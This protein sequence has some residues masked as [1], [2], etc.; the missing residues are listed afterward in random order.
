MF[1]KY[2]RLILMTARTMQMMRL[3]QIAVLSLATWCMSANAN[4][5]PT[6]SSGG[7]AGSQT[8]TKTYPSALSYTIT[9]SGSSAAPFRFDGQGGLNESGSA[10]TA[11]YSPGIAVDVANSATRL[12][13][14]G[15][16]APS[17]GVC[18]NRGTVTIAFSQPVTNPVLHVAGFG[19]ASSGVNHSPIFRLTSPAT[20]VT[21]SSQGTSTNMNVTATSFTSGTLNGSSNCNSS[22]TGAGC[23]SVRV[24]GT[25]TTLT[26]A[27]DLRASGSLSAS[28]FDTIG[29]TISVDEDFSDAPTTS[30]NSAQAPSHIVGDLRLGAT[31][32]ADNVNVTAA[33]VS[34]FPVGAGADNNGSNGD[35]VD[36]DAIS[37]FPPLV[38]GATSYSLT[39]PISGAS[40]AGLVCGWIDFDRNN[41]FVVTERACAAF[42]AGQTSVVLGWNAANGNAPTGLTAGNNY[43]RL[44]AGYTASQIQTADGKGRADSGEVED[45]RISIADL[46]ISGTVFQDTLGELLADGTI[47]SAA[48]PALSGRTVRLFNSAGTQVTTTTTAANGSYTFTGVA[49]GTYYVAVDAP[50]VNAAGNSTNILLEQTYA[51][52]GTGNDGAA[53]G[54]TGYGPLC[55]GPQPGY[56]QQGATTTGNSASAAG[57]VACYGGRRGVVGDSGTTN[58]NDKEH[59][60]RVVMGNTNIAGVDFGFSPYVATNV[61][62]SGQGSLLQFSRNYA[63][64]NAN[65]TYSLRVVPAVPTNASGGGGNWWEVEMATA[66]ASQ[67]VLSRVTNRIV[68]FDGTPYSNTNGTT[69]LNPNPGDMAPA[70]TAVG[71]Q[72]ATLGSIPRPDFALRYTGPAQANTVIIPIDAGGNGSSVR[73]FGLR[74][75]NA[76][77]SLISSIAG[78]LTVA[79]NAFGHRPSGLADGTGTSSAILLNATTYNG[80]IAIS[81]NY[82]ASVNYGVVIRVQSPGTADGYLIERNYL[83]GIAETGISL[84]GN[85]ALA[86]YNHVTGSGTGIGDAVQIATGTGSNRVIENTTTANEINMRFNKPSE[87]VTH[88]VMTG[89]TGSPTAQGAGVVVQT[90]NG[91]RVSQNTFGGNTSN[92][93]DLNRNGVTIATATG[94]NCPSSGAANAGMPRPSITSARLTG[95]TL[96]LSGFYCNAGTHTLEFYKAGSAAGDTGSDGL[97]AGEGV[98]YLGS[99]TSQTGGAFTNQTLAASGLVAGDLITVISIRADGS[100]SEFSANVQLATAQL[101]LAKTWANAAANDAVTVSVTDPTGVGTPLNAVADTASETDTGVPFDVVAGTTYTITEAFATGVPADYTKTLTCTGNTGTGAAL[102]YTANALS[103][104]LTVGSTASNIMCTFTNA[105]TIADLSITKTNTPGVNGDVDQVDDALLSGQQTTYDIVVRHNGGATV[106]NAVLRDPVP[107]GLNACALEMPTP[108]ATTGAATCPVVGSGGGQL[109]IANLQDTGATGGVLIPSMASGSTLT[110][111]VTCTV[112]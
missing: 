6:A 63:N 83:T 108:C 52:A 91:I 62:P 85:G 66:D 98:Q 29:L 20:G 4:Q 28:Q 23:G 10:A 86:R 74:S 59:V 78:Q 5:I 67:H 57:I 110:V 38:I 40:K 103:G 90:S 100:T 12:Q 79:S 31:I 13:V 25:V 82:M 32:D 80:P 26:F 49:T 73:N 3:M 41:A 81:G 8:V 45:Y 95:T 9:M 69:A 77:S 53:G 72:G 7:A 51:A 35:G 104:T 89:A 107:E 71:N 65:G 22:G 48:N 24:N 47:G 39:V 60:T 54:T 15:P 58:L 30:F 16:C 111:R 76:I 112:N 33:T 36:E 88:N 97:A 42:G 84:E 44:R 92:A 109:S 105:R 34:P 50:T 87:T 64:A 27:V 17:V 94:G 43:V 93:I 11:Y 102:S 37:T 46:S 70:S 21:L 56:T 1:V 18:L 2:Q 75:I 19:G 61:Q 68:H 55:V 101:T 99:L 14:Y 96:T 106:T